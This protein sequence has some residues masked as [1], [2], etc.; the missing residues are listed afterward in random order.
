MKIPFPF[1]LFVHDPAPKTSIRIIVSPEAGSSRE[2]ILKESK[3]LARKTETSVFIAVLHIVVNSDGS[4]ID[5]PQ[6][7]QLYA[8][9]S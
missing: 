3:E 5:A 9:K 8:K 7:A 4:V 2:R 6:E 1:S